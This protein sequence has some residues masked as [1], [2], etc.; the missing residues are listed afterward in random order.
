MLGV[1]S[2]PA[3]RLEGRAVVNGGNSGYDNLNVSRGGSSMRRRNQD[4]V[5]SFKDENV[6]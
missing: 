5:L 2:I 1:H 6:R 4:S 3:S